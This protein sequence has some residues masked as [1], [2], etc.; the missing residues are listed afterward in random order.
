MAITETKVM[1]TQNDPAVINNLN[2]EM[3]SFGWNVLSIQITHNQ[4]TRTYT[5]GLDMLLSTGINT[6][7][8]TTIEYATITYQRDRQMANYSQI[9][10]LEREYFEVRDELIRQIDA[11]EANDRV[12]GWELFIPPAPSLNPVKA[13]QNYVN[14][15]KKNL[16]YIKYKL[17]MDGRSDDAV[18]K[19][20]ELLSQFD[21]RLSQIRSE[22]ESLI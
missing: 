11:I 9:I 16:R 14:R 22:A 13:W 20:N 10:D 21:Y 19:S 4:N 6:V 18:Q 15:G 5:K 1:Q 7:E 17:G 2:N 12:S 3:S 8:T